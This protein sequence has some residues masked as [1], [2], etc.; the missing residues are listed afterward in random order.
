MLSIF[1]KMFHVLVEKIKNKKKKWV[2]INVFHAESVSS[3]LTLIVVWISF[4]H[5]YRLFYSRRITDSLL[6]F[7]S[8]YLVFPINKKITHFTLVHDMTNDV[9]KKLSDMSCTCKSRMAKE[10]TYGGP[11]KSWNYK[12]NLSR[13]LK[14]EHQ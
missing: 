9:T 2:R 8:F 13:L 1:L 10:R 3:I 4:V 11:V 14:K 7:L 6:I 5:I 12:G